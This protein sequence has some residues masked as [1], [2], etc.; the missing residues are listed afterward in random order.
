M[1]KSYVVSRSWAEIDLDALASN[2]RSIRSLTRKNCEVMAVVKADAYGHGAMR[3]APTLL[4]SGVS[5]LAVSLL[6]EAINLRENGINAP[7]LILSYTD[8]R[9]AEEVIRYNL[10]QT[11]Y[12]WD[13]IRALDD[14]GAKIGAKADV[15][16]KIDTGMGRIGFVSGFNS[17][18]ETQ[19]VCELPNIAVEGIFTHFAT[20][21]EVDDEFTRLQFARFM[22]ICTELEK[23][24]IY[25]PI[26]HCCNS[27]ATLRYPEMHLD[28]V[29]VG[30]I[31][32]GLLPDNCE[33]HADRFKPAM[34]L[35]S[36]VIHVKK[37]PAGSSVGYGRNYKTEEETVIA[38]IPIGYADGYNRLMSNRAHA[39]I[40]GERVPVIGN[41]CMD[42][43]MLDVSRLKKPVKVG[44]EVV[45][46]GEQ[47]QRGQEAVIT[48]E[49][50]AAWSETISYEVICVIGKRIPRVFIQN[51][52]VVDIH[53]DLLPLL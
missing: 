33:E 8:P 42:A 45:L 27:A 23:Q 43:C 38:T 3:T 31:L 29:R 51:N 19:K 37:L 10:T 18:A 35:K 14:A 17:V 28:M 13:L 41:I 39:L 48:F 21:D 49:D 52:K 11:V 20:A 40:Q 12:S 24:G 47:T 50:L 53:T 7:I 15:H 5:R 4:E 36:S 46:V 32:F 2:V 26:K 1:N 16:I 22:G 25:I 6:D 9:R 34:R 44:D 30:L